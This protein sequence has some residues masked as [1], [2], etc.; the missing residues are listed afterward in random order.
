MYISAIYSSIPRTSLPVIIVRV[1]LPPSSL[2]CSPHIFRVLRTG[3]F[4][5]ESR[6]IFINLYHMPVVLLNWIKCATS[7]ISPALYQ[8]VPIKESNSRSELPKKEKLEN[9]EILGVKAHIPEHE[10]QDQPKG[11]AA[12]GREQVAEPHAS[13]PAHPGYS[14]RSPRSASQAPR[15]ARTG[16]PRSSSWHSRRPARNQAGRAGAPSKNLEKR[17]CS[18]MANCQSQTYLK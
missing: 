13:P 10:H 18:A 16:S 1:T 3:C 6:C 11:D 14:D 12:E 7:E 17:L 8:D 2:R 9:E 4:D 15:C 5:K